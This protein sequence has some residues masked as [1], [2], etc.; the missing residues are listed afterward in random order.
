MMRRS[1]CTGKDRITQS[2]QDVTNTKR[3]SRN[4]RKKFGYV[5][6]IMNVIT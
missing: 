5:Y 1:E 6:K 3:R 4:K 2:S